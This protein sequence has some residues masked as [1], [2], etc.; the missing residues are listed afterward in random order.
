[1]SNHY[2]PHSRNFLK[3]LYRRNISS[4]LHR[5]SNLSCQQGANVSYKEAQYEAQP[6]KSNANIVWPL[7]SHRERFLRTR[8]D[9]WVGIPLQHLGTGR[10]NVLHLVKS[11]VTNELS[12]MTNGGQAL[13]CERID[14]GF[15]SESLRGHNYCQVLG[16]MAEEKIR[17]HS[18]ADSATDVPNAEC[19]GSDR[20]D[21]LIR[22]GN[23]RD[24]GRWDDHTTYT[25]AR[26]CDDGVHS[27]EIVWCRDSYST[28]ASSHERGE[29]Y[30]ECADAAFC[31]RDQEKTNDGA[32][33][34]AK[35]DG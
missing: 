2:P 16:D 13:G 27:R 32:A 1:V 22:A 7:I 33:D 30:H 10:K 3:L 29:E 35:A 34:D 21:E 31:D 8:N 19:D 18:E 26:E 28:G 20:R 9:D 6:S 15:E 12:H 14:D 25:N 4:C 11:G 17:V 23:L 24:D 5:R